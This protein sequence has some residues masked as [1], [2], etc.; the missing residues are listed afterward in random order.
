MNRS[1]ILSLLFIC[2]LAT[3]IVAQELENESEFNYNLLST[4]GPLNW[5]NIK[6]DFE[7]CKTGRRQS[8]IILYRMPPQAVPESE[9]LT[10]FYQPGEATLKNT[11]HSIELEWDDRNNSKIQINNTDYFLHNVHWH[12][13]SEHI[14]NGI[15]YALEAHFVHISED[16]QTAV[17]AFLYDLGLP[18]PFLSSIEDK[19]TQISSET[20][21]VM[22][23]TIAPSAVRLERFQYYRYIGSLTTPP[24]S[25]PVLWTVE[26]ILDTV[27]SE[28]VRLLRRAVDD[29]AS[30]NARPIQ[31]LNGRMVKLYDT[32]LR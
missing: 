9:N 3:S 27:S 6:P 7:K 31:P 4:K 28:Q 21:Q 1:L 26:T 14:L 16:N 29:G 18:D 22:A 32:R 11:G 25:E 12:S 24:C 20:R 30:R 8:P 19:L 5:G 15:R 2:S 23:G 10:R 17:I 13:P